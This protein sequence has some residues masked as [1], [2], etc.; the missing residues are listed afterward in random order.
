MTLGERQSD[1]HNLSAKNG[2]IGVLVAKSK[3]S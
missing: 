3:R 2:G 1:D